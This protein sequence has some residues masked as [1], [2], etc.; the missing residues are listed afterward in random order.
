MNES[1]TAPAAAVP[2]PQFAL[3]ANSACAAPTPSY[4]PPVERDLTWDE[5]RS[6]GTCPV[7]EAL[8]GSPCHPEVGLRLGVTV[9]GRPPADGVHLG[10]LQAAPQRIRLTPT[11]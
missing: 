5:R 6:W 7:C 4:A 11:T 1:F 9:D 2:S 10:R 3:P 8:H